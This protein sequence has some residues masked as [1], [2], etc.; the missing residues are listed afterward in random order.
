MTNN[1]KG[2]VLFSFMTWHYIFLTNAKRP[3]LKLT[4]SLISNNNKNSYQFLL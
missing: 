2:V 4:L 1:Y 3:S